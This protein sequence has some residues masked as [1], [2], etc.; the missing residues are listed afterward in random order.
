M[1]DSLIAFQAEEAEILN[2]LPS[3]VVEEGG[4]FGRLLAGMRRLHGM[5]N[6]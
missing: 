4:L 5:A 2:E 3:P 6:Q 1:L